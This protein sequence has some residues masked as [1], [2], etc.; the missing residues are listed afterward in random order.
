MLSPVLFSVERMTFHW[1]NLYMQEYCLA[2]LL[3]DQSCIAKL[4][5]NVPEY[6]IDFTFHYFCFSDTSFDMPH[7]SNDLLVSQHGHVEKLTFSYYL[8]H[9]RP[10]FAFVSF[11]GEKLKDATMSKAKWVKRLKF[12]LNLTV[13][14]LPSWCCVTC[15]YFYDYNYFVYHCRIQQAALKAYRVAV[16][17]L[18]NPSVCAACVAFMEMLGLDST[19]LRV[20]IQAADR[21]LAH[22]GLEDL[23]GDDAKEGNTMEDTIGNCVALAFKLY[24]C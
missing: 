22:A 3:L 13:V 10:S 17:H 5:M 15:L 16:Q 11:I 24:F 4:V 7:F 20:D 8:R 23:L 9:G 6:S 1:W 19:P 21:L 12:R 2:L 18:T 14:Y